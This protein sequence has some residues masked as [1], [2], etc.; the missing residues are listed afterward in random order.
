MP[1]QHFAEIAQGF[2]ELLFARNLLGIIKLAT[3]L[4]ILI[5]HR[6]L[7]PALSTVIWVGVGLV[8]GY[9]LWKT[10]IMM[11]RSMTSM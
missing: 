1:F 7:M 5:K 6:D 3:N 10:G 9:L 11:L 4:F 2:V 8:L